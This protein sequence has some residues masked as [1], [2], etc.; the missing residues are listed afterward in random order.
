MVLEMTRQEKIDNFLPV[1]RKNFDNRRKLRRCMERQQCI[2]PYCEREMYFRGQQLKPVATVDHV[3]PLSKGGT[4]SIDNMVACC[5]GC[6]TAK[7]SM[8]V[9]EF[10]ESRNGG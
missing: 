2:C 1:K 8:S 3:I 9:K 10:M 5:T 4:N 7:G 6:N